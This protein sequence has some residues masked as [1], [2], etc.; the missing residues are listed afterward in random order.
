ME[1]E[2]R[3]E[4]GQEK[5]KGSMDGGVDEGKNVGVDAG[6]RSKKD[7]EKG[8]ML[9]K[10]EMTDSMNE[11][12]IGEKINSSENEGENDENDMAEAD[13]GVENGDSKVKS[14][15]MDNNGGLNGDEDDRVEAEEEGVLEGEDG[16]ETNEDDSVE[17]SD[18][19]GEK[20]GA[21]GGVM[22]RQN[23]WKKRDNEVDSEYM[24][25]NR[26]ENV[27]K[28]EIKTKS[29]VKKLDKK[30]RDRLETEGVKESLRN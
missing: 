2:V 21:V 15:G 19:D 24:L 20:E 13:N 28:C 5:S 11:L 4:K 25:M 6:N 17:M 22:T 14:E 16:G 1:V 9:E 27:Q 8:L 29:N 18:Y 10:P 23:E 30:D 26:N 12:M 3:G 7:C